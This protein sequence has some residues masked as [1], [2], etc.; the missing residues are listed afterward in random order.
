MPEPP[1]IWSDAFLAEEIRDQPE[2][3][4]LVEDSAAF[5]AFV[6]TARDLLGK[7][8]AISEPDEQL[9]IERVITPLLETLGWPSP[10]AK[11]RLT[12]RDE[13]DLVLHA[14]EAQRELSLGGAQRDQ[15]LGADGLVECKPWGN[16]FDT[17]GSGSR[18]G[19]TAAQQIQRYLL[20]AGTDSNE[21]LRWGILTNG[22][23]WRIYS[24]RARPR[25]R[26]WEVD[27]AQLL[28][29]EDLFS[30]VLTDD[31]IHQLRLA[32][33]LLR[34]DSWVPAAGER[35]SFLDRILE[36]G[37]RR[38]AK[39][40]DSLSEVIFNNVYPRLVELFWGK[41][42]EAPAEPVAR[43]ALTFLYRLLFIYYAEDRG[44]LD[45]ENPGYRPHSLRYSVR[46]P[47]AEQR[48][49]SRFST[50]STQFWQRLK[51]LRAII[52][53]G[54]ESIGQP[55]YNGGLFSGYDPL[56][57]EIEL[58]DAELA[59]I[60]HELSHTAD[61]TY[62]SYRS[63]EV[64]QLGSIYERLLERVPQRDSDGNVE[65]VISPY[66][67]KD[68]GSYYTPQELVDLIVEQTLT[69]LVDER[70]A[71]FRNDP[72]EAND[73]AAA[74]LNLKILDPAMGSGHFLIT[75]LDW[76]TGQLAAL[77][78]REWPEAEPGYVSPIRAQ[79]WEL[80]EEHPDL[81]DETLL[82]RMALKRCIYGVDKNPLA[83]E[84]AKVAIW[85]HTFTPPLPL[86]YISH[87]IRAGDSLLGIDYDRAADYIAD[88]GP[89]HMSEGLRG[90]RAKLVADA[91]TREPQ[92]GGALDLLISDV[93]ESD[94]IHD[95]FEIVA[96]QDRRALDLVIAFHWLSIGMTKKA[97]EEFHAPLNDALSGYVGRAVSI[98]YN[99][100]N[101]PGLTQSTPE[102]RQIRDHGREI[103]EREQFFHWQ[104]E[105][106]LV[107]DQGGFDAIVTNPPWD[108]IEQQEKEWFAGRRPEIAALEPASRRKAAIEQ[109]IANGDPLCL[110]YAEA[111]DAAAAMRQVCRTSGDYPLLSG[112]RTNF[113]SLFVERSL[114]LLNPQGIAG[115]LTPSGI[116]SDKT[117]AEFF[118]SVSTAGRIAGI[119]D[120]ENRRSA[121]PDASTARWFSEVHP[122]FK[123]CATIFAGAERRFDETE[124]G[125]YL[126]GKAD[127]QNADRVFPLAP[128]DFARINP[129]TG[130]APTLRTA[131]EADI[132]KSIYRRHPVLVKHVNGEEDKAYPV[133]FTQGLFNMTSD[134]ALFRTAEQ[135]EAEG[136]YPVVGHRY[137]RGSEQWAPLYQGRMIHHFDHRASAVDFNPD[138]QDNPY[139]SGEVID[140]Q[141]Q[142]PAFFPGVQ[143]WVSVDEIESLLSSAQRW[144]VAFR[145]I[146]N[147]TNER[148]MIATIAPWSA[149]GNQ[150]PLLLPDPTL[151]A[152][153]AA[154]LVANLSSLALDF[155][156]KRKVQGTHV[157]WFIV[158]QLPVIAP[159]DYDRKFGETTAGDLV[160]DH[161]LRLTYTAHDL[162]PFAHDLGYEGEPFR[163]DPEERRQLRA[164]LDALYFHLYGLDRDD[165]AY[166]LGQFPVLKK[167]EKAEH[168]PEDH[169]KTDDDIGYVTRHLVLSYYDALA[170]GDTDSKVA[171]PTSASVC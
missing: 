114:A 51:T 143:Y 77:V 96:S 70:I 145:D 94:R 154:L 61:G 67:R 136:G 8:R 107:M 9:T 147:S 130:T 38:D 64:R 163:W 37:R 117:A 104:V 81:N 144:V 50:V 42:P 125:F 140:E 47:I 108:R 7:F 131:T 98:L 48:G 19:E 129:N 127:L 121:N 32:W 169:K 76:L 100:E 97:R 52:D 57:D 132:L 65:V 24:Y 15:V 116:Y 122:Q 113:Y 20:I 34:R 148:T 82:Q 62:I 105:F 124:C 138:S 160:H 119:Y 21:S 112:G 142:D 153:N 149:F 1:P 162:A 92:L 26:A 27:L 12:P 6:E 95:V 13:V 40:A 110:Q 2:Y 90:D 18:P 120:F 31:A 133:R 54:D 25:D 106:A 135:I 41:R 85:L 78:N 63:L 126:H 102:F 168:A 23:R 170:A 151:N 11:R 86:P 146:T 66:A 46:D 156:A 84:L 164:R 99:G 75:V 103:A 5:D 171:L 39:V 56:L 53:R 74:L 29:S 68:S 43:A 111:R 93:R 87:R 115:L 79:L 4:A 80:Q 89:E 167:N 91:A 88:W 123:F 49:A 14:D 22:A 157:N 16:P 36:A 161:V 55:A 35:E 155:V 165:T 59:P 109:G 44:M 141:K 3:T 158:E 134:S 69:P 73:P 139:V 118:R 152:G 33:L 159:A 150:T 128:D 30:Q 45:T 60:I 71:A 166:V 72:D 83:V 58:S 137:Q 17:S 28:V 101:K 10:V